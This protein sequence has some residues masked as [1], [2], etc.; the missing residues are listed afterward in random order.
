MGGERV[1]LFARGEEFL[2]L[3][4][5]GAEFTRE[6][7]EENER[8][9]RRLMELEARQVDA[10]CDPHEWDQLRRDLAERIKGLEAQN[11][12]VC[13]RLRDLEAENRRFAERHAE[14][15]EENNALANLYV[16]SYQL[17]STLDI[18]EVLKIILE[19][20]INLIGAD[21]FA[22]HLLDESTGRLEVVA[23]EGLAPAAFPVG[24]LGSGPLGS[25]VARGE[26]TC[27]DAGPAGDLER[28]LVC[29]PLAVQG[30]PIGAIAIH[31]LFQQKDGFSPLDRELFTMLGG[32]AATA[33]VAARLYSQSERKLHT[34]QGLIDLL[35]R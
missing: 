7:L 15:E 4:K 12:S 6:L 9:R 28:P 1:D 14:V 29:I 11:R 33:I 23:A 3:F 34:I 30:R 5:R 24:Q 10:A 8:L 18:A 35:A 27:S 26:T 32:H 2:Q 17:H 13:D 19:I 21:L 25:A 20:V 22:I 16:A 31:R